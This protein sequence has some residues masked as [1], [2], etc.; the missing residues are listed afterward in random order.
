MC[1]ISGE[2]LKRCEN[3]MKDEVW[4]VMAG[5]WKDSEIPQEWKDAYHVTI[6][7]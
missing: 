7:D 4:K 1:S 2:L 3:E 5:Y 6:G